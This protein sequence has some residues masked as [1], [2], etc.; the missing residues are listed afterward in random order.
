MTVMLRT[1][2]CLKAAVCCQRKWRLNV[3]LSVKRPHS[4]NLLALTF[5][6]SIPDV[7][8]ERLY[9]QLD[10]SAGEKK[11]LYCCAVRCRNLGRRATY[12]LFG[13]PPSV[14]TER[15]NVAQDFIQ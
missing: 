13:S 11:S 5:A 14:R 1:L 12:I 2:I 6:H 4:S 10:R 3:H 7:V 15:L 9:G 8:F